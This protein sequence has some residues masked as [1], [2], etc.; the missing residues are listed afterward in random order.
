MKIL[1]IGSRLFDDVSPYCKENNITSI[2]TESNE[3]A[4]NLEKAT[5]HYIVPR[6]MEEPKKIA[7]KERVDGIIPL[8]GID[9]PLLSV[10]QLKEELKKENIPVLISKPQTVDI[11]SDKIKTKK[12][13]QENKIPTPKSQIITKT[14]PLDNIQYPIV[15]KQGYGQG[16][17]DIKICK[18]KKD[19][20]EYFKNFNEALCEEFIE[21]SEISIEVSCWNKTYYPIAPIYKGETN[22]NGT[23]PISR[24]R[25]GPVK[26]KGLD[27]NRIIKTAENIAKKLDAEGTIDID[28]IYSQK[29]DKIYAI[30]VNTRVSGTRY[31]S[32]ATTGINPLI[33][34]IKIITGEFSKENLK[35]I[36]KEYNS[37]EIPIKN[38]NG[39]QPP[40][41]SKDFT[42][43]PYIIH[44]P[45]NYQ[46]I[47]I[48]G[49][50]I[51][52]CFQIAKQIT[53]KD[54]ST[55]TNII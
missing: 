46:R 23:H 40:E 55:K 43:K 51:E 11:C 15:L 27:N 5:K 52:D 25:Y 20:E 10:A 47:T 53:G 33:N 48:Q 9:P 17:K 29:H 6:G 35:K 2:I 18:N 42:N 12:F 34:L 36:Y 30:E 37:L 1:F 38:Y 31:L 45:E 41:P 16:G 44:G 4:P 54:Y 13:F 7:I 49:K 32:S 19:I 22:L 21:G 26:I 8:I 39:P 14:T 28:L 24:M 50:T 3:N